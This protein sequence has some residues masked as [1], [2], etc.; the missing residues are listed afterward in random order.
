MTN[1]NKEALK[2]SF[3]A[4]FA[5]MM[6]ILAILTVTSPVLKGI[7]IVSIIVAVAALTFIIMTGL[8]Y[9]WEDD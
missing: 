4:A 5:A 7:I 1:R 2:S 3:L 6:F 9:Y 8:L